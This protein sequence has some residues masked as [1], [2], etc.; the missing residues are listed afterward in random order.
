MIIKVGVLIDPFSLVDLRAS[1]P[2]HYKTTK[3]LVEVDLSKMKVI[4]KTPK[5]VKIEIPASQQTDPK[6]VERKLLFIAYH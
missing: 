5:K 3:N 1:Q 2:K 6:Q 4:A